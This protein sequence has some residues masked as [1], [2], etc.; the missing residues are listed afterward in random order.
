MKYLHIA[1]IL[2]FHVLPGGSG[3]SAQTVRSDRQETLQQQKVAFFNE[4]LQLT[5]AESAQI[6]ACLQRLPKPKG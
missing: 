4:K 6:L 5:P 3:L 2:A 1:I